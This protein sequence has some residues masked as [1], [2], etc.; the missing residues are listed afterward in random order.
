MLWTAGVASG[1]MVFHVLS[2]GVG[3]M[4]L[5]RADKDY[6]AFRRALEETLRVAPCVAVL[7]F[8]RTSGDGLDG[9]TLQISERKIEVFHRNSLLKALRAFTQEHPSTGWGL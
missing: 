9:L 6:D 3:R 4:Q 8:A 7:V 5:F 2:S 1:G